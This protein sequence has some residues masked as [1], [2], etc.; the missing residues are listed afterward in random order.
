MWVQ[1]DLRGS[2]DNRET[3]E[4][5]DQQASQAH[6]AYQA[7]LV[8]M[9]RLE[10]QDPQE[11]LG[12]QEGPVCREGLDYRG[13]PEIPVQRGHQEVLEQLD[14]LDL[15]ETLDLPGSPGLLAPKGHR[16]PLVFLDQL[17]MAH[18]ELQG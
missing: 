7:G 16:D 8:L 1:P 17:E 12:S 15:L 3:Q 5:L 9:V 2:R 10:I 18:Q 4:I 13:L 6:L 14:S 11:L